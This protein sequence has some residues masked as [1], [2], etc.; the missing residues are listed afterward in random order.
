MTDLYVCYYR[1]STD[2][3]SRSGLGLEAQKATT[4][5]YLKR[6]GGE[7]IESFEEVESGRNPDRQ[8][9]ARAVCLCKATS[10]RLLVAKLDRIA[11][12]QSLFHRLRQEGVRWVAADMPEANEMTASLL[13]II[14]EHEARLISERTKA[15]LAAKRARGETLGNPKLRPGTAC[16]AAK[17]LAQRRANLAERY[18]TIAPYIAE[19]RDRGATTLQGIADHLTARRIETPT[20]RAM[21]TKMLVR[22]ALKRIEALPYS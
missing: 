6:V 19:A 14:A 11:R 15:A 12:D 3:Q 18:R 8:Q 13:I 17:A 20:R 4:R 1:V 7:C 2:G 9:L 21:W 16:A 22:Q 10:A 5:A